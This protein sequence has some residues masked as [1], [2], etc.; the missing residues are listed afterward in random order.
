MGWFSNRCPFCGWHAVFDGGLDLNICVQCGAQ[1]TA[2]G[3]MR[4][5]QETHEGTERE[6]GSDDSDNR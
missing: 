4:P 2:K 5:D 3:W 1:E 6:K